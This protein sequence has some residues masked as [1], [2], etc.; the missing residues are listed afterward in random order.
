MLSKES[1]HRFLLFDSACQVCS[2]LAREVERETGGLLLAR[3]LR[4]PE[5]QVWLSQARPG[6]RWEPTLL[7]VNGDRP[8]AFTGLGMGFRLVRVLGIRRAWRLARL[9]QRASVP[10]ARIHE[11]RRQ[12]L[13][14]SGGTLFSLLVSSILAT[15]GAS[16]SSP[17]STPTTAPASS[18]AGDFLGYIPDPN[19]KLAVALSSSGQRVIAYICDGGPAVEWFKGAVVNNMVNLTAPS[20]D[21]LSATLTAQAVTG[22]VIFKS[23]PHTSN[24]SFPFT[25]NAI[26]PGQNEVGLYRSAQTFGGVNYLGG[27]IVLPS[28]TALAAP[29]PMDQAQ[30]DLLGL[31]V[32]ADPLST[33]WCECMCNGPQAIIDQQTGR[34]LIAPV[35]TPQ[36][37]AAGQVTVPHL[38]TFQLTHCRLGTCS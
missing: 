19:V 14:Y 28:T 12:F 38:G 5:V 37:I 34:V 18:V 35:L 23:G 16:T 1:V 4:E 25:A 2:H 21:R 22:T 17:A 3:S 29:A 13:R 31:F 7:E 11:E 15:C 33:C 10:T 8:R 9:V 26:A 36:D 32:P 24:E 6:W 30:M 27:W 20:G